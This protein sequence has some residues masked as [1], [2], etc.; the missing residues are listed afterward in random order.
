M[1]KRIIEKIPADVKLLFKLYI[2]D[3]FLF[4]FIR[5]IFYY[6]NRSSDVGNAPFFEKAMAFERGLEFDTSVFC[7]IAIFPVLIWFLAALSKKPAL[8]SF[9]FYGFLM[10]QLIYFFVAIAD[11]PFF[12]QFGTHLN[13]TA[14][15]WSDSPNFAVGV[16][17]GSFSYWGFFLIFIP[18]A[19]ILIRS[20]KNYLKVFKS[21]LQH[22]AHFKW[23]HKFLQFIVM[24]CILTIGARGRIFERT[25]LHEGLSIVSQNNFINQIAINANYTFWK[26]VFYDDPKKEY[27][28]P[29]NIKNNIAFTRTYLGITSPFE[30]NIK[31]EIIDTSR[32]HHNYNVVIVVMESMCLYKMGYYNGKKLTPQLDELNK[33][34]VFFNNFFSSGIHTF[35]GLFSISSGYPSMYDEQ[36]MRSYIKTPFNGLGSLLKD[37]GYE[38]YFYTTHDPHFDNMQGYFKF[39]KFEHII[40]EHDFDLSQSEGSLGVPDHVLLDRLLETNNSRKNSKPFLSV[41][42]TA[43]D[44]GPW[45][46]PENIPFKPKGETPQ[47]NCTMYADWSI[48]RFIDLAKKQPWYDN[49][50]FIFLGDHGLSMGH[51]YEMPISY[52]HIPCI[53]HQP[54]LFKADTISS[55][56]YQ[57]D[58]TATVMGIL[59]G[60]YTNQTFGINILKEKHSYVVFSADDKIGCVD[61]QGYYYYKTLTNGE[62]Y[63]RKYKDLDPVNYKNQLKQKADSMQKNM[64]HIYESANYFIR[65]NYFL[66]E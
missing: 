56:C 4:F 43:S 44:H 2:L 35:N 34:S 42:M 19:F 3:L 60:N 31:R 32:Q 58:I 39:N 51:T 13:R 36:P 52:N 15:L 48:G 5:F 16:I 40:S 65:K 33:E 41:V 62:T 30:E 9:G 21:Q 14:F 64:M 38:T 27:V 50:V 23:H 47:D 55:P 8:Y 29:K 45:R 12:S 10:L 6:F 24:C 17:F 59:G 25:G 18:V 11:I 20:S 22:T 7:W 53:I 61:D 66:Y 49:T 26:S 1:L 57:P 46:I 37:R 63:L 54:K 28:I